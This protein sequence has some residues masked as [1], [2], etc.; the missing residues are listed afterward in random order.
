MR[1]VLI[2]VG[3]AAG[4]L[5]RLGVANLVGVRSLPVATLVVNVAGSFALG[6]VLAWATPRMTPAASSA[7]SVGF[8]GGFTT[9]STFAMEAVAL[10][11]DGRA[12]AAV[13]YVAVSVALGLGAAVAGQLVGRSLAA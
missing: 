9:F 8:L 13:L 5:C 11:E 12:A 1:L 3:G 2:S 10:H 4:T 6:F 7:L